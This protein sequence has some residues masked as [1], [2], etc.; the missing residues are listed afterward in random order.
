MLRHVVAFEARYQLRSPLFWV[1]FIL[2]F[3]LAFGATVSD[4][5]QIGARGNVNLNSPYAIL[6]TVALMNVFALFVVTAFVANVVIRDDETGFAAILRATRIGKFDYL[7]GRFLGALFVAVLL[8]TAVPLAMLI[9]SFMPWLDPEK[10]GPLVLGHYLYAIFVFTV[11]TMFVMGALFFILATLT[12]SMMWSYVGVVVVLVLFVATRLLL[13]DPAFDT[14]SGLTD[15][16]GPGTLGRVTKYWTAAERNTLTPALTG[17]LL[18]NRL[19]WTGAGLLLLGLGYALFRWEGPAKDRK[20]RPTRADNSAAPQP[21]PLSRP[22]A[23]SGWT[24]ALALARFDMA[25]VF[26]SPAFF[27]LLLVGVFN[28]IAGLALTST[29]R[30]VNYFPVSRAVIDALSGSYNL[31][32]MIIAIYYAGELVWRNREQRMHEIVDATAAPNWAFMAPKVLAIVGVLLASFLVG[33]L[34]GMGFQLVHGYTQFQL[35]AYA[36]WFVLPGLIFAVELAALSIFVQALVPHKFIGWA[37]M[38]V[39]VVASMVL[40]TLGFEHNLYNFG[41]TPQVPLSDMN[42]MGHFWVGRAWLQAYWLAFA[43][44]L[45]VGAH[46]MWRRGV[47]TRLR[48]R[49]ARLAP[50]LKRAPGLLMGLAFVA[51]AG[52]GV[53]VFYNTNVLN[54]YR[55]QPEIEDQQAEFEKV[56]LPFENLPQPTVT[57]VSLNVALF[58]KQLRAETSGSYELENR[59]GAALTRVDVEFNRDLDSVAIELPGATLETD[60][61]LFGHRIYHLATPLQPGGRLTLKFRNVLAQRGFV[62]GT[63][64][65]AI[66]DNGSFLNNFQIAPVLGVS[67][68]FTLQDR[69]KR[70]KHGLPAELRPAKLEDDG[71]RAHQYLRHDSDWVTADIVL[72]TDA[73]QTPVAPGYTVSDTTADGRRTLVTKTESP[74]MNFFSLQ[75][76]RYAESKASWTP[77]A[78]SAG[79]PVQLAVYYL[80]R[81]DHNVQRMLDAMKVSLDT[82]SAAFTPFQFRQLRVTEF[83]AYANFAQSFANTVPYSEG[84]GFIQNF[85]ESQR[86]E[87]VDLVTYVTA[88]EVAHQ[89][90]A[91][92]IIGADSQGDTLLSETFAQYSALLVME[93]LYGRDQIRKFLKYELDAYLRSRGTELIEELPLNRV[94]NQP[95]IHYRKGAVVMYGLKDIVGEEVVNRA[96]QKLLAQYAFKPAPYPQSTDFVRLLRAEAGPKYDSLITDMFEKITLYDLKASAAKARKLPNGTYELTLSVDARKLYADGKGKETEAP[97]D[98]AIDIGVFTAEP[99]KQGFSKDSVLLMERRPIRSGRQEITVV[100]KS[101]PKFAGIDP[102]N[103]RIDRNSDDN[104]VKVDLP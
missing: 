79:D 86:D 89:W 36:L 66:V 63:P 68:N 15:P 25:A 76:A 85:D 7:I 17:I 69:A 84:I 87:N 104:L 12:R 75:S 58:P 48:P 20:T 77:K 100:V 54:K 96:L 40:A 101:L 45:L 2:F 14:I 50:Q 1:G 43:L 47:E 99:G 78:G 60:Y 6:Q 11:P 10:L 42:D 72:S 55:T 8:S 53:Y 92:Q 74:I 26:K 57:H 37:V 33:A 82:F 9:G 38:L 32:P 13:R 52:T 5:I 95:Y 27:V 65:T 90:W 81:H 80:P 62:V 64:Q 97:L 31:I 56:L 16:F 28:S 4:D 91:H 51:W 93:R 46:L 23:S 71:A 18:Y 41:T 21:K 49:F 59:S 24:Q 34:T 3:L 83:P 73:D 67:R 19:I 61:P 102:Y 88:H 103:M 30:G 70:R 35:E 98:E 94:E 29:V 39:Y 44:M 22:S